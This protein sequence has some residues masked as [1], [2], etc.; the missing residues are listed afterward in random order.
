MALLLSLNFLAPPP[1][2]AAPRV[3]KTL[4]VYDQQ[5]PITEKEL[6]NFLELLPK[7]RSWSHQNHEEAHPK[8][9]KGQPD[10]LYSEQ[11]ATWIKNKGWD[12]RRFFCVMGKMA[13]ALVIVEEGNDLKG[14]RPADMPKVSEAEINLAQRHLAKLLEIGEGQAPKVE[15]GTP[16]LPKR[17]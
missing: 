12:V 5:A 2:L 3:K 10:F 6:L 8:L 7:F 9:T 14:T 13:A 11:A 17:P 15:V 16:T 1:V 4:T